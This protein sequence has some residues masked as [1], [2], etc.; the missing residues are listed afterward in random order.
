MIGPGPVVLRFTSAERVFH[1]TYF[2]TFVAL[3]LT[4]AFLYVPWRPFATAEAGETSRLVHRIFAVVFLAS[5]VLPL[6]FSPRRYLRNLRDA[7]R[8]RGADLRSLWMLLT[9][10]YWTGDA[11]GLPPQGRFTAG[12]KL[13]VVIQFLLSGVLAVTGLALWAYF[14]GLPM[15]GLQWSVILHGL[16]AVIAV[17]FVAIHVYMVTLHPMTNQAIAAMT[18]GTVFEEYA[19]RHHPRWYEE[20]KRERVI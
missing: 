15:V 9:R 10:Y 1:W 20:L 16:S 19:R 11:K 5:P 14:S 2:V 7:F 18:L 12:Q 8:W 6:I 13:H 4:G 17:C 3:A